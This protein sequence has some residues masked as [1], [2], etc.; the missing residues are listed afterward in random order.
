M[1]YPSLV[2]HFPFLITLMSTIITSIEWYTNL[3]N[4]VVVHHNGVVFTSPVKP[5]PPPQAH[6]NINRDIDWMSSNKPFYFQQ[7]LNKYPQF[8]F[9]PKQAQLM[10]PL[11]TRLANCIVVQDPH[12][13]YNLDHNILKSWF[14]LEDTLAAAIAAL[15]HQPPVLLMVN[16]FTYPRKDVKYTWVFKTKHS[17][18]QCI[19]H[20]CGSLSLS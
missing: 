4:H 19:H 13:H 3:P 11:L 17:A 16:V 12:G 15:S 6:V 14:W 10:G 18:I 20:V 9:I 2:F 5:S 7:N 8:A 1:H